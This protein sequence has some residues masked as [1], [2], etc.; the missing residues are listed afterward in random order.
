MTVYIIQKTPNRDVSSASKFGE[1]VEVID[2][3]K[4]IALSGG[5]VVMKARKIL[6]NFCDD[7]FLL[8]MGYPSIIGVCC[9]ITAQ[10]NLGKF[11]L[12]KWDREEQRYLPIEINTY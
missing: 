2:Y 3:R 9:E 5:P 8:L 7:D 12:L 10:H 11:K 6:R 1:M 4:Q